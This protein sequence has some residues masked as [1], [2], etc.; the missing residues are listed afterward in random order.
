M[1]NKEKNLLEK[2]LLDDFLTGFSRNLDNILDDFAN[3][4][5]D[6][7]ESLKEDISL[8]SNNAKKI[9]KKFYK[10]FDSLEKSFSHFVDNFKNI[11]LMQTESSL[12]EFSNTLQLLKKNLLS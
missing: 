9:S 2:Q 4:D 8:N 1:L 6:N 10:N 12:E 11:S 3:V 7:L 5:I